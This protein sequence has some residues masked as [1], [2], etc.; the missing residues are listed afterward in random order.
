A[1][2]A[3]GG[4]QSGNSKLSPRAPIALLP[5]NRRCIRFFFSSR[6][7][8]TRF[9][10]DWSSDVCSSDLFLRRRLAG[11]YG[12]DEFGFDPEFSQALMQIGRASCRERV[13]VAV[14]AVAVNKEIV[15]HM[16]IPNAL[17]VRRHAPHRGGLVLGAPLAASGH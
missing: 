6:R 10:C 14:A 2:A 16:N 12:V 9:D 8:H 13:Y 17:G 5:T 7:R 11:D 4:R 3:S 15:H 1:V